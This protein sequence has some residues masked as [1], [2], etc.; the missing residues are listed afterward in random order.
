MQL[1][2]TTRLGSGPYTLWNQKMC[3]KTRAGCTRLDGCFLAPAVDPP[4]SAA[5]HMQL[6][7]A[8]A[9]DERR[10][11]SRSLELT[12]DASG[13]ALPW[14]PCRPSS[15]FVPV[16]TA[17]ASDSIKTSHSEPP[18]RLSAAQQATAAPCMVSDGLLR[19]RRSQ[20][21]VRARARIRVRVCSGCL[22]GGEWGLAGSCTHAGEG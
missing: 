13:G 16:A 1:L 22:Q 6:A 17:P 21:S 11:R 9:S 2:S 4:D 5:R 3:I 15:W 8:A 20:H 10:K 14:R 12:R 18:L 7:A 19:T